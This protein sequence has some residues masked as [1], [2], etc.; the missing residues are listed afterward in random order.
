M[1]RGEGEEAEVVFFKGNR[2][3]SDEEVEKEYERYNL[4]PV[5]PYSLAKVNKDD[6][7]FADEHP[8]ATIWKDADGN[9]CFAA[10]IRWRGER[11]VDIG[12][13]GSDRDDSWWFAG[14]RT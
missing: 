13:S 10:F 3:M 6:P 14:L 8:N 4:Y 9:W 12:R 1:P 2:R 7:A 5:D 11:R